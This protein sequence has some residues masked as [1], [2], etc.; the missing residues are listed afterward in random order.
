MATAAVVFEN[1]RIASAVPTADGAPR[2]GGEMARLRVLER[3][4][5]VAEAG[6]IVTVGAEPCAPSSR[7]RA[8]ATIVDGRG[9]VLLP[10]LVDCHTHACWAGERWAEWEAKRAGVPYLQIL[11]QGGGIMSTVRAVRDAEPAALEALL[12]ARLHRMRACG[13]GAL[14]V[15]TGYGLT[16]AAELAMLD[17]ILAVARTWPAPVVPTLLAGHARDPDNPEQLRD[18]LAL[19]PTAAERAPGI[20]V[21]A[22]CEEGAWSLAD[23]RSLLEA[24]RRLGLPVRL[25]ADQFN[26]LGGLELAVELGARSVDHLEASTPDGVR[27]L[28]ASRTI[29]VALP[30][31]GFA[32]DGR[33][34]N[35]RALV[36]AGGALALASNWN[37]GSAPSPSAAFAGALAC[38]HMGVTPAEALTA[39][40]WNAAC[41]LGLQHECGAIAPG[42]RSD[43]ILLPEGDERALVYGVAEAGPD[44][45]LLGTDLAVRCT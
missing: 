9:R 33:Y 31:C 28:A 40:T 30:A 24:A 23:C 5:L 36:D 32:L 13:T 3:G 35:A 17:A 15:K 39:L 10:A 21:D 22:F 42:M 16:A 6:R 34:A 11:K 18:M 37:P 26:A 38:R 45:S 43:L 1:V 19:L 25:H 41:V 29:G 2:R 4:H 27:T 7:V 8:G 14:E 12:R 44:I 20:A